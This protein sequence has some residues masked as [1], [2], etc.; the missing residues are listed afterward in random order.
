MDRPQLRLSGDARD[1]MTTTAHRVVA[2][3]LIA[4]AVG[5]QAAAAGSASTMLDTGG[6]ES[7]PGPTVTLAR[8][9]HY[10]T[11]AH[12]VSGR[13]V[14]EHVSDDPVQLVS[15]SVGCRD[16]NGLEQRLGQYM[17]TLAV[18]PVTVLEPHVVFHASDDF[19]CWIAARAMRIRAAPGTDGQVQHVKV[20][21]AEVTVEPVHYRSRALAVHAADDKTEMLGASR[22]IRSRSNSVA[23]SVRTV[24][25]DPTSD[26]NI[27]VR[28]GLQL[29]SCT[30]V[31]GSSDQTTNGRELCQEPGV[32]MEQ[33]SG[34]V[35]YT[36][37]FIRQMR[38]DGSECRTVEVPGAR[39]YGRLSALRH[40]APRSS[41]GR[42]T[43]PGSTECGSDVR[44]FVRIHVSR[45]PGVVVH[46]P[47]SNISIELSG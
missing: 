5:S 9:S 21:S 30:H 7:V 47:G 39:T 8:S 20:R 11:G 38:P 37:L 14:L 36:Q 15:V 34:P 2:A 46:W 25:L 35:V 6:S 27:D 24:L 28:A 29:T 18:A 22:V 17:N 16:K 41:S 26:V 23:A 19:T 10:V 45:G 12:R 33:P 32:S 43:L 44:A 42:L 31:F 40:H 1:R 3:L 13:V 4:L